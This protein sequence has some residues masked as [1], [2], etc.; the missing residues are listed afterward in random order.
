MKID[1]EEFELIVRNINSNTSEKKNKMSDKTLPFKVAKCT[2][3]SLALT[4]KV[5]L[6]NL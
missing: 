2:K 3:A 1:E 5:I 6:I 4:N